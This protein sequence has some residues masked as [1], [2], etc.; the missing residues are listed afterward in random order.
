MGKKLTHEVF[1]NKVRETNE[2]IR[3][4]EI[5]VCGEYTG[6]QDRIECHCNIHDI[7]WFPTPSNLYKGISC[8]Q[9]RV[10]NMVKRRSKTN[11]KFQ[12]ELQQLRD[13]GHDVYS[14]DEYINNHTKIEFYCSKNH[15]WKATPG[16][17]LRGTCCPYCKG[18]RV[19]VGET[20]LWDTHPDIAKLLKN[21]K[22]GYE[23]SA[24]SNQKVYFVCPDCGIARLKNICDAC[25]HGF[26]CLTCGDGVSYPNKFCRAFL[27][28]LPI[29]DYI[30][31]Y[32]PDWAKPYLYDNF[33]EYNGVYYI[34]EADG[35][36]HYNDK[37]EF[38]G[39]LTDR[40]RTDEI[41]NRLAEQ[42]NITLIR[43][44]CRESNCEYIKN[45]ILNS[46]LNKIFELNSI[47]WVECDIIAQK[48]LVKLVCELYMA[49]VKSTKE[50]SQ[51][52][53]IGRT[54]VTRY[55]KRG[56]DL[57]WCDYNPKLAASDGIK[58]ISKPVIA[59]SIIDGTERYFH[60]HAECERE[61]TNM[62]GF[63]FFST[64][65]AKACDNGKPY[66]GFMFKLADDTI[67][68]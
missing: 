16:A 43:I 44:D 34:L 64:Y 32:Q 67:Q 54:T 48:N 5:E 65:I 68:N 51:N 58:K 24:G 23:Y 33:F 52:L 57:Q 36:F 29:S 42:H 1:M 18:K 59:T 49:G 22:D 15:R 12:E 11:E 55:L 14:D 47:D 50:I 28:Q 53:K 2:H 37:N 31:E 38:G 19:I 25:N 63:N 13:K 40:Q 6:L 30:P 26:T 46:E 8:Q 60:S 45:E 61:L 9:C 56:V 39:T 20:S 17:V 7:T 4:G 10:D 35:S 21:P 41:K 3:R 62:C 27:N 66:K